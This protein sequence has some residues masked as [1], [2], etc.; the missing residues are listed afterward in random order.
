MSEKV[1]V[2]FI[3]WENI[4]F[5]DGYLDFFYNYLLEKEIPMTAFDLAKAVVAEEIRKKKNEVSLQE[6]SLGRVYRPNEEYKIG[7][8][9][10]FPLLENQ[11]GVAKDLRA[12]VNPDILSF[13]VT[14]FEMEDG[15]LRQFASRLFEHKLNEYDYSGLSQNEDLDPEKVY[16]R[17][18]RKIARQIHE[19]LSA[20]DGLVSIANYWFP[21]ALL[22]E[23]N[24]GY[25]N[26]A[27]AVLEME[28]GKPVA[29][30]NILSMI[31]YPLD[32]NDKLTEFSFNYALQKDD[33]FDEVGP[34]GTILWALTLLEPE[35]VRKKPLTLQYHTPQNLKISVD[36]RELLDDILIH[37]ELD[38]EFAD[39]SV[40]S[41]DSFDIC[42]NYPHWKAGTLPFIHQVDA[43][44]PVALETK[45]V[46]FMFLDQKTNSTFPGWLVIPGK[47]VSGL[48]TWYRQNNVMPGSVIRLSKGE[49]GETVLVS[50]IPPR[51]SKDW[52]RTA[53]FDSKGRLFFETRQQTISTEFDERMSIH[54]ENS[55]QLDVVWEQYNKAEGNVNRLMEIVFKD[56]ARAT[57]QGIVHFQ[58]IYAALNMMRRMPPSALLALLGQN[59]QIVQLDN[60]Y[61]KFKTE[62]ISEEAY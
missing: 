57:P 50:L 20:S 13:S 24:P 2:N 25:L 56:L 53:L 6:K 59:D 17:Y 34:T 5:N 37:D 27:E 23:I 26:L 51:A 49:T 8:T 31:E 41:P 9:I 18:G 47:Y 46:T 33:R 40:E 44:F 42:I 48:K 54:V 12:G 7:E 22:T 38:L 28:E 36:E 35:D 62:D 21:Q 16:K 4:R 19:F 43:I 11:K 60:L 29:T 39:F 32:S 10:V 61:F 14:T 55:P 45:R 3:D 58:E 15:V 30:A 1:K 52:V